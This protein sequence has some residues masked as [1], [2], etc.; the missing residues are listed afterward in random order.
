M[1]ARRRT[2]GNVFEKKYKIVGK[3]LET[4]VSFPV[5]RAKSS[6]YISSKSEFYIQSEL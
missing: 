1:M 3:I 6:M 2:V 4:A 5:F